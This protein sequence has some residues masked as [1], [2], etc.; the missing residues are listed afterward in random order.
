MRLMLGRTKTHIFA[1]AAIRSHPTVL[2]KRLAGP[3]RQIATPYPRFVMVKMTTVIV[4]WMKD[5]LSPVWLNWIVDATSTVRLNVVMQN[6]FA[7]PK[8]LDWRG[9]PVSSP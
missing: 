2:E 5:R 3:K 4:A 1:I 8:I 7:Y 6:Q 9:V